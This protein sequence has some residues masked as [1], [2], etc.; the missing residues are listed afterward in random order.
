MSLSPVMRSAV[1]ELSCVTNVLDVPGLIKVI[2]FF[3]C[4]DVAQLNSALRYADSDTLRRL[5][6]SSCSSETLSMMQILISFLINCFHLV[7]R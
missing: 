5:V 2:R 6:G 1:S 7:S 4:V 3:R